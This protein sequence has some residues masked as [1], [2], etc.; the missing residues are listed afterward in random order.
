MTQRKIFILLSL[1]SFGLI[2]CE[3]VPSSYIHHN[4]VNDRCS[5]DIPCVSGVCDPVSG[6]CVECV[7]DSDCLNPDTPVCDKNAHVCTSACETDK[8]CPKGICDNHICRQI[9]CESN[10]DC[11]S[12][13]CDTAKHLCVECVVDPDCAQGVC[14]TENNRCVECNA[15]SDCPVGVC[16]TQKHECK[17]CTQH[18]ECT[19]AAS[20]ICNLSNGNC[21]PCK[22]LPEGENKCPEVS[23]ET[24]VCMSAGDKAGQCVECENAGDCTSD[25]CI[26]N[27]CKQCDDTHPC[28]GEGEF[29]EETGS[30]AN[31]CVVCNDTIP[32]NG[33]LVCSDQGQCVECN[34]DAECKDAS[35][36]ACDLQNHVCVQ[37]NG[38]TQED[39]CAAPTPICDDA[40]HVCVAC[41]RTE[42]EVFNEGCQ[43]LDPTKPICLENSEDSANNRCVACDSDTSADQCTSDAASPICHLS[44]EDG[45]A[46]VC[47]PCTSSDQCKA[48][49]GAFDLCNTESG[50]CVECLE[51]SD[52][53]AGMLFCENNKC[54]NCHSS[55]DCPNG[56]CVDNVCKECEKDEDCKNPDK[57]VCA[58]EGVNK[59]TCVPCNPATQDDNCK[60]KT[61]NDVV[62]PVCA[63]D[64]D[65]GYANQC[66][67][68][69]PGENPLVKAKDCEGKVSEDGINLLYCASK[70]SP[71][72][73]FCVECIPA[74][75]DADTGI[76][77]SC[78]NVTKNGVLSQVCADDRAVAEVQNTCVECDDDAVK[79][80]CNANAAAPICNLDSA[81]E[82]AY[83]CVACDITDIAV[84]NAQCAKKDSTKPICVPEDG[85]YEAKAGSCVECIT[86]QDCAQG[87]DCNPHNQCV[88]CT[89][90]QNTEQC[91]DPQAAVCCDEAAFAAGKCTAKVA[92]GTFKCEK[93]DVTTN[94]IG[95]VCNETT[96]R[97]EPCNTDAECVTVERGICVEGVCEKCVE[98]GSEKNCNMVCSQTTGKCEPCVDVN[99]D[100]SLINCHKVCDQLTNACEPCDNVDYFC[101]TGVCNL[102]SESE[103]FGF[104]EPCTPENCAEGKCGDD[105]LCHKVCESGTL[106]T[107]PGNDINRESCCVGTEICTTAGVCIKPGEGCTKD[108]DC[109]IWDYCDIPELAEYGTC[110][111]ITSDPQACFTIPEF[112]AIKPTIKW[113]YN[114]A[115][116]SFPVVADLTGDGI[117]EIIFTN[118]SYKLSAVDG[119]TGKATSITTSTVFNKHND[120]A[121][122]DIDNDGKIEVLVPSATAKNDTT[123]LYIMNLV[124]DGDGGFKWNQ[125]ALIKLPISEL[126]EN[127]GKYWADLHPTVADLDE[128][129][130]PDII[131]TRGIINGDNLSDWHC[132]MKMGQFH[133]W[134][135]YMFAVADLDQ[136]GESEI[137]V[138]KFYDKDCNVILDD[139][140]SNGWG[141][142]AVADLLPDAGEAGE[143]VPEIVRVK[144]SSASSGSVSVWKVYKNGSTWSQK[145]I[146]EKSHPGGGGGNPVIAD[147]DGDGQK[148]IGV[149]GGSKFAVF[150]G[151]TGEIMWSSATDDASSYRTGAAVFD[152][153][154]D[155]KA[156]VVYRDQQK[157]RIY[158]GTTGKELWWD[159][160]T[161]GTVIDY[162][163]IV[164]VDGDGQ[165]EI[166]VVSEAKGSYHHD[167]L[168]VTVYGDTYGKWVPARKIWN[169]HSYHVTN[170][171]DDGTV[172]VHEEAN[173]LNKRLNNYR[174][175][176]P[177]E[178]FYNQPNFVPGLLVEDK[179]HCKSS[180]VTLGLQATIANLGDKDI[181]GQIQVS[182]YLE[183]PDGSQK[184]Y[185]GT[186]SHSGLAI[187]AKDNLTFDWDQKTVYP[188]VDGSISETSIQLT[189]ITGY[190]AVFTVDDA[191]N[192][193]LPEYTECN[194]ED[195]SLKTSQYLVLTG[196]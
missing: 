184:Y 110:V 164:D 72:A 188:I 152:F 85:S 102:N 109:P 49:E 186:A 144:A 87:S 29:C 175:N 134:Y 128:N 142:A 107:K 194:E 189:D 80:Q 3:D 104:C 112:E 7:Q 38:A 121:V 25:V 44:A 31:M 73:H 131:T 106:C 187:N 147:F 196:C 62:T 74:P 50:A 191:A 64:D 100:P 93:C 118:N 59:N 122:A 22:N 91:T 70:P 53:P 43:K 132:K 101:R 167:R 17:G 42:N 76:D 162:P 34:S 111:P 148:D 16:N 143:L 46:N 82:L 10:A 4:T 40:K 75:A 39:N 138:D 99:D 182:F 69:N 37:C 92:S 172:P 11:P 181:T 166:V 71:K 161:S 98:T 81:S 126:T 78:L 96:G 105:G 145:K 149:A 41:V 86:A 18:S 113:H 84:G 157:L 60:D 95:G 125:K 123:G 139:S 155:G 116:V 32:C 176:V 58:L 160:S 169:Q 140:A 108:S 141:Y 89:D 36:P 26:D 153:E 90:R 135:H 57:P 190:K 171:N 19:D 6:T 68:C 15:D 48:K 65:P 33:D 67:E 51:V 192:T 94:C 146:W 158:D 168:G 127:G 24:P 97:C 165:T 103:K 154:A 52:C 183:S 180:P 177:P 55:E 83:R 156:E 12:G 130:T 47:V 178:G 193:G 151:N 119:K 1:A 21:E 20:P 137:I 115:V 77:E 150:K 27:I 124:D 56:V 63:V 61:K 195:N 23:K 117:P 174:A 159:Y 179:T 28:T 120:I 9:A 35:K 88:E 133:A 66:Y 30:N 129:G 163:L 8:D 2:G 136:D 79:T 170:I 114:D 173:W 185:I 45:E 5:S 14:D 13:V 54:G